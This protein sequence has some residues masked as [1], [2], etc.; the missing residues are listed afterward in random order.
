M[1]KDEKTVKGY[2]RGEYMAM[3]GELKTLVSGRKVKS[4]SQRWKKGLEP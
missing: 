1:P 4:C 3:C 2:N